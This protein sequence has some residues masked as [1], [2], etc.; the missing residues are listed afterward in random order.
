MTVTHPHPTT[1][2][3][4][5]PPKRP[6]A[7]E[8]QVAVA[9]ARRES[10]RLARASIVPLLVVVLMQ[11][12]SIRAD[13]LDLRPS[14]FNSPFAYLLLAAT[15]LVVS[16]RAVT[17][18]RRDGSEELLNTTPAAPRARTAGHLLAVLA[19]TTI[20]AL[21]GLVLAWYMTQTTTVG[22][23]VPSELAVGPLLVAG[24]G[25]LGVL[26][27]RMWPQRLTPYLACVA[28]AAMELSVNTPLLVGSGARW[29][30]FWVEG[31]LWWLLPRHS[32]A[33]LV[34]LLGLIAMAAVGALL[35]HGL[36]RRLVTV[37][38]A[39]IAV[40]AGA[41]AAQMRQPQEEWKRA[42]AMFADPASHQRCFERDGVNY[43]LF[44]EFTE[45]GDHFAAMVGSVRAV[46]PERAWPS[47]VEV[48]QRVTALDFQYV[49]P[50][51][52]HLPHLPDMPR[53]RIRQPDD[54]AIHP[55]LEFSWSS[56]QEPGFGVQVASA[57]IGLPL[58]PDPKDGS[59]CLAA[60]QARAVLALWAGAH[61][62]DDAPAGLRW[63]VD[64]AD[65]DRARPQGRSEHDAVLP[66][67]E[68]DVYGG[69]AVSFADIGLA[70][71]MLEVDGAAARIAE[72]WELLTD[73]ATT[74]L[75]L[76]DVLGL[77][78]PA[79]GPP[80]DPFIG[81]MEPDIATLGPPCR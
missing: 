52:E 76:A 74:S 35:R 32:T 61:A 73:P 55:G 42:N 48:T 39:S 13:I 63:L 72:R 15:T 40:T 41:A 12:G 66:I 62:T 49:G 29:L 26:L 71:R 20:A 46:V 59:V 27:A 8:W 65:P 58:V 3:L 36:T 37:A 23:F 2:D 9:I 14:S 81:H 24:A 5:V 19:P 75:Q 18:S 57:A 6:A 21:T 10:I 54:G 51:A 11:G 31:S 67:A 30:A 47:R 28:I 16:H 4:A 17:R 70:L 45:L 56:V 7:F 1:E 44:E 78:P 80:R 60:G 79:T 68:A 64:Q 77:E 34:Y 33:H 50:A 53:S 38:V 43:C 25:C 69:F 22:S